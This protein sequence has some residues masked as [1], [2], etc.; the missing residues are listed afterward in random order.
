MPIETRIET[1]LSQA[2]MNL[3]AVTF[4]CAGKRGGS[5]GIRTPGTSR[6][7]R[8]QGECIRPLCHASECTL[9]LLLPNSTAELSDGDRTAL[10]WSSGG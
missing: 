7:A 9:A 6:Y 2:E 3:P 5:G 8:F 10:L 1:S 4:I